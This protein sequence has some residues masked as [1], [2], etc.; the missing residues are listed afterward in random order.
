MPPPKKPVYAEGQ[1]VAFDFGVGGKGTGRIRGLAFQHIIDGWI[2]EIET[3]EGIDKAVYPWSCLVVNHT[4]LKPLGVPKN[5]LSQQG[6]TDDATAEGPGT[7]EGQTSAS[8]NRVRVAAEVLA[9]YVKD[10]MDEFAGDPS[11]IVKSCDA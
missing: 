4:M 11:S 6:L 1:R 5:V 7:F 9:V 3:S 8:P 2:V 10:K